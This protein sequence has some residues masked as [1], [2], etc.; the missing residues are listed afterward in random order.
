[1]TIKVFRK[2][3]NQPPSNDTAVP[4]FKETVGDER[5]VMFIGLEQGLNLE[6]PRHHKHLSGNIT[7]ELGRH[8]AK[9]VWK[10]FHGKVVISV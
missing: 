10:D 6:G 8:T 5:V 3:S 2:P 4:L 1:M 9:D 7:G